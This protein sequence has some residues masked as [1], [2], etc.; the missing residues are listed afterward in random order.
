[1]KNDLSLLKLFTAPKYELETITLNKLPKNYK[2]M[3][4]S[5]STIITRDD[6]NYIYIYVNNTI[7]VF[8]PSSKRYQD[9]KSLTY[10]G[11]IE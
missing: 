3:S 1:L 7:F 2:S 10:I 9:V 5:N 4:P 11:Q 6:L 8:N